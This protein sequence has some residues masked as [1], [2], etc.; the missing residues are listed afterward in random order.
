MDLGHF[1]NHWNRLKEENSTNKSTLSSL[2]GHN[3]YGVKDFENYN[4]TKNEIIEE[5][6]DNCY[7]L[8][9]NQLIIIDRVLFNK[10][11]KKCKLVYKDILEKF[12]IKLK[13]K[14]CGDNY[15]TF[16]NIGNMKCNPRSYVNIDKMDHKLEGDIWNNNNNIYKIP[17][18]LIYYFKY[19]ENSITDICIDDN[20][21]DFESYFLLKR[22]NTNFM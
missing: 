5:T 16:N 3:L 19:E 2:F 6:H 9:G 10:R 7:S 13:C 1:H 15:N 21:N 22:I 20:G 18:Y 11:K 4:V 17:I 8:N 12:K 14:F